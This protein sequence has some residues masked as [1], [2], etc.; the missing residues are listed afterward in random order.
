MNFISLV[1]IFG[2]NADAFMSLPQELKILIVVALAAMIIAGIIRKVWKL[3][4]V[5]IIL[6]ILYVLLSTFGII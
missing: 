4:K 2:Q 1:Y 6:A 5:S 3:V